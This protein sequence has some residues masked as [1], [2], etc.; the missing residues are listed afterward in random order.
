MPILVAPTWKFGTGRHH[1]TRAP[2]LGVLLLGTRSGR[3]ARHGA[4][5]RGAYAIAKP[6]QEVLMLLDLAGVHDGRPRRDL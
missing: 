3:L 6:A 1:G 4:A 2:G 5:Q